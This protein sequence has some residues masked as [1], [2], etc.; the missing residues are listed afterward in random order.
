MSEIYIPKRTA[1]INDPGWGVCLWKLP[2]GGFIQDSEQN[3][4]CAYGRTMDKEVEEKMCSAA[5]TFGV[6]TGHAQWMPGFRKITT[7]EWEDEMED[8]LDGGTPDPVDIYRQA[9]KLL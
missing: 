2:S 7:S 5:K 1:E 3:Y 8:L 6:T 4:L 9:N